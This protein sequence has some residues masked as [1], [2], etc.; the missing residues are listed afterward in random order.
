M[1]VCGWSVCL[2]LCFV[3]V[4]S[5]VFLMNSNLKTKLN[6][7]KRNRIFL[8]HDPFDPRLTCIS[9]IFFLTSATMP[10]LDVTFLPILTGFRGHRGSRGTSQKS[11][12]PT[13]QKQKAVGGNVLRRCKD[14]VMPASL[15][16]RMDRYVY[17]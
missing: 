7:G 1:C 13:K 9:V 14:F 6:G 8:P 17:N 10:S 12:L 2:C 5:S 4:C 15:S 3:R 11:L 16:I